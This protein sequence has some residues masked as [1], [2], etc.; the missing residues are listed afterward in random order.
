MNT[1]KD[2]SYGLTKEQEL[3]SKLKEMHG[4][5]LKKTIGKYNPF[6]FENEDTLIE[7]KSRRNTKDKYPDTM[8]SLSKVKKA[9]GEK[10]NVYFYFNF[11]DG[12]YRWK[13][14]SEELKNFRYGQGGRNDRGRCEINNYCYIP[15]NILAKSI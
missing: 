7:L 13:Y 15:V 11:T 9:E 5:T 10:R 2:E 12:L 1:V 6:D 14:D 8:V 3:F 4:D